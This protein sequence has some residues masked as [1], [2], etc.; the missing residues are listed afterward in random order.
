MLINAPSYGGYV[1]SKTVVQ[2][3][4]DLD[5]TELAPGKGETVLFGL[6]GNRYEIDLS[7]KNAKQLRNDLAKYVDHARRV[8]AAPRRSR[9][10]STGYD[11]KA[12]RAWAASNKVQLSDRGRIPAD[13]LEQ[14]RAAG[15]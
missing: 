13:V 14:F 10:S 12:V 1:A 6:D 9:R 3:V 2:I 8:S 4:D 7:D 11:A 15:N 5:G